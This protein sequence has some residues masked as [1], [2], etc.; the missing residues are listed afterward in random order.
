MTILDAIILGI[1]EGITEFLPVSST[2]HLILAKAALGLDDTVDTY[3]VTIQLGA[4]LAVALYYRVRVLAML[5]GLV[6][7]DAN[8]RRLVGNLLVAFF[9]AVVFGL[10]FDDMIEAALFNPV[11]VAAALVVGGVLMIVVERLRRRKTPR[12]E[13][14]DDVRP[15][16]ALAVGF[17]QC[18]A[19]WP[20]MSRSMSTMVGGQLRGF[21][22]ELAADFSFLLALPTLGAATLYSMYKDRDALGGEAMVPMLVG[23]GVS[24]VAGWLAVAVFL[25]FIKKTG[26]EP[27]GWYRIAAGL[28]VVA[29]FAAGL[30]KA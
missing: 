20:G 27:F 10:L 19:L 11:T 2:G 1:V 6:G 16:D 9:P 29:L 26:L 4:T 21:S 8:G 7:K 17:A 30:I 13:R 5:K 12:I 15:V 28:V 14:L 23:L 22:N 3:L 24:F 25:K 18:F